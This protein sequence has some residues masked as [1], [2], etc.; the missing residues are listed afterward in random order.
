MLLWLFLQV[1]F[2]IPTYTYTFTLPAQYHPFEIKFYIN[3]AWSLAVLETI[4]ISPAAG[5]NEDIMSTKKQNFWKVGTGHSQ[6][7]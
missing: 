5:I 6:F 1:S 3:L 7:M 2:C 4:S